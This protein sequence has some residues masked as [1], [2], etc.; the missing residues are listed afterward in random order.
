MAYR[1]S[2]NTCR[3]D[4]M[5]PKYAN[6]ECG[7]KWQMNWQRV[8]QD[9]KACIWS[10]CFQGYGQQGAKTAENALAIFKS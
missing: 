4:S 6:Q 7:Y 1:W 10:G 8:W 3:E 2:V 5:A 9:V